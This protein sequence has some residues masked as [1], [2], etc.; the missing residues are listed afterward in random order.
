MAADTVYAQRRATWT[1]DRIRTDNG[2]VWR[3]CAISSGFA[4]TSLL[5]PGEIVP[6]EIEL[7][8]SSTLY[9]PGE[10][11]ERPTTT[12]Q[13]P[14]QN[15]LG[16]GVMVGMYWSWKQFPISADGNPPVPLVEPGSYVDVD[17]NG[18]GR[19]TAWV[20]GPRRCFRKKASPADF[21]PTKV[22]VTDT[23]TGEET[24]HF[25]KVTRHDVLMLDDMNNRY[26]ADAG[27]EHPIPAGFH[28]YVLVPNGCDRDD[29]ARAMARA[30][31][32][33]HPRDV[34]ERIAQLYEEFIEQ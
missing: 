15:E 20:A 16:L 12:S 29:L 7:R 8:P 27:A 24:S 23:W 13:E 14:S 30:G 26:L 9:R 2:R 1:G 21:A 4:T 28:W 6:V 19:L 11:C 3:V 33:T 31:D 25:E 18:F 34:M 22:F 10:V 32:L 17:I 5:A